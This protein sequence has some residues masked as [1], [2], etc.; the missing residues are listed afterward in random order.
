MR[1]YIKQAK[2]SGKHL[3]HLITIL[4]VTRIEPAG[5]SSAKVVLAALSATSH[6]AVRPKA[7]EKGLELRLTLGQEDSQE[8]VAV[9]AVVVVAGW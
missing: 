9:V 6:R 8:M 5:C 3:L 7:I 2:N 1:R 4:D